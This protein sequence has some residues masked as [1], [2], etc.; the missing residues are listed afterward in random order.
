MVGCVGCLCVYGSHGVQ[1]IVTRYR[2]SQRYSEIQVEVC[3]LSVVYIWAQRVWMTQI[4][5]AGVLTSCF[6]FIDILSAQNGVLG[7]G[8]GV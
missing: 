8:G 1:Y 5:G 3:I 6:T 4:C 7:L 2:R